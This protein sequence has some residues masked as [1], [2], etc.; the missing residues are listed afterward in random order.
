MINFLERLLLDKPLTDD[1]SQ[2]W[3]NNLVVLQK[4]L[5]ATRK[6][7]EVYVKALESGY[8]KYLQGEI[9]KPVFRKYN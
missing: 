7:L 6:S 4:T 8:K 3:Q 5:E 1:P 9:I 2:T